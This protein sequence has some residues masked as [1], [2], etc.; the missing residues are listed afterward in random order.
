MFRVSNPRS[1]NVGCGRLKFII[2]KFSILQPTKR[3]FRMWVCRMANLQIINFKL[4]QPTL[5]NAGFRIR[6]IIIYNLYI[7]ILQCF[8]WRNSMEFF[9]CIQFKRKIG[10]K[11]VYD[12]SSL[13]VWWSP[14]VESQ[15]L[16]R[17]RIDSVLIE[18]WEL[19]VL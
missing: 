6:N 9:T 1:R 13:L 3:N 11:G 15:I 19:F 10:Q 17:W 16:F 7:I 5:R 8:L 12:L 14:H 18:K 2:Y 4:L